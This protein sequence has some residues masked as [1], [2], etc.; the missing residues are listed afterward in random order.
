MSVIPAYEA[1]VS[2]VVERA[3]MENR[4]V[5]AV[6]LIARDGEIVYRRR[7]EERRVGKECVP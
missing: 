2:P 6:V 3:V 1:L 4:L 7:S 5:G